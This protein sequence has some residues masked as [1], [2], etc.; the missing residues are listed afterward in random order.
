M[1]RNAVTSQSRNHARSPGRSRIGLALVA[2]LA[3]GILGRDDALAQLTLSVGTPTVVGNSA[4]PQSI[5]LVVNN[6]GSPVTVG[7]LDFYIQLGDG[8][9]ASPSISSVDLITATGFALNNSGQSS[10]PNNSAQLQ[11]FGVLKA[12]GAPGSGAVLSSGANTIATV[13]FVTTGISSGSFPLSV[14]VA[15][16]GDTTYY[17][18]ALIPSALGITINN[19][20]LYISAVPEPRQW[21]LL[22]SLG[23]A[24]FAFGRRRHR[25]RGGVW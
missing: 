16:I 8:A 18:D 7:A 12:S 17:T 23:L 2:A 10:D 4:T 11:Y 15:G 6:G 13:S 20:T 3:Y 14:S 22:M 21:S 5:N 1:K 19:G 24:A 9:G 25:G